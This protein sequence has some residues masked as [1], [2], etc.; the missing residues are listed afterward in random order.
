MKA[1][2]KEEKRYPILPA[3]EVNHE[4]VR[5]QVTGKKKG[6]ASYGIMLQLATSGPD[7]ICLY[8]QRGKNDL[9]YGITAL[10]KKGNR[11]ISCTPTY[12]PLAHS[13]RHLND[14]Q[15]QRWIG[16]KYFSN[17]INFTLFRNETTLRLIQ[18]DFRQNYVEA[19]WDEIKAYLKACES[20]IV[21]HHASTVPA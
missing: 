19:L 18:P 2:I 14:K 12:L 8:I 10:D 16:K 4:L 1:L 13:I 5:K 21:A 6:S 9:Y 11:E 15:E 7:K 17:P 20:E 3:R